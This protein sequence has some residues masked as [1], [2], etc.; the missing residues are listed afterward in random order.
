MHFNINKNCP[1]WFLVSINSLWKYRSLNFDFVFRYV[2]LAEGII[3]TDPLPLAPTIAE[4]S[5]V[6]YCRDV[7]TFIARILFVELGW[8]DFLSKNTFIWN[9]K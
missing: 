7:D 1:L 6:S 9:T 4:V 3:R 5:P 8:E 2:E